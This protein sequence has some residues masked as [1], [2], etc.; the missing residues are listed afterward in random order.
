MKSIWRH[1]VRNKVH[2]SINLFGL[3]L[4]LT[5]A[6]FIYLYVADELSYDKHIPG[7]E[8]VIRLQPTV[9][10]EEGEQTWATSEGFILPAMAP[11]YPEIE[12][13][14]RVIRLENDMVI[15]VGQ[16]QYTQSGV[17]TADSAF[18]DVFPM[19]Y[20]Y[21]T[22][23]SAMANTGIIITRSVSRKL[24]GDSD[25]TG[26]SV[27]MGDN[28]VVIAAVVEDMPATSHFRF[29]MIIPLKTYWAES[30]Q[31]RNMYAF[32]SYI[33][34]R[35]GVDPKIFEENV[36]NNWYER[37]GYAD[38]KPMSE[39]SRRIVLNA[40]PLSDIHLQSHEE[41]EFEANGSSH[42]IYVFIGA[43]VL[44]MVIAMINF[45]N[46]SNAIAIRRAKEVA[47]R[48]TIGASKQLL[49]FRFMTESF[50]F[51]GISV[52]I[53]VAITLSL[54]PDFNIFVGKSLGP[55]IFFQSSFIVGAFATW[56]VIA[57][58]SGIYP[59]SILSSYDAVSA[60]KA[61]PSGMYQGSWSGY[62]RRALIVTQF[63]ISAIMIVVSSIIGNQLYF[64]ENRDTG[65]DKNNVIVLPLAGAT[66]QK[67]S[68][69]KTE[70]E[71]V[72]GVLSVAAS[73]VIPGKRVV[74]LIV[75]VPDLAG[76]REIPGGTDIGSR[77]MR[78]ISVDHDFVKTLGLTMA[79]G[80]D[81][82]HQQP[83]DS[84]EAFILNEAAVKELNLS[85]PVGR[86]FEY[87]FREGKR[88]R[89]IGVVKDFNFASVHSKIEPVML[90]IFPPMYSY[91][92]IKVY[93]ENSERVLSDIQSAWKK[94][95]DAPFS[96]EFLD[97]TYDSLYKTE[98]T[99]RAVVSWFMAISMIIAGLGLFGIIT[100]FA[101]MRLKE[102]GIRKV[103]GA[104]LVSLM[105]GLSREYLVLV[106]IG[107]AVAAY[108]AFVLSR[109]WLEQF[110]F[111][112]DVSA[113]T[114]LA[115]FAISELVAVLSIAWVVL[116]T[117]RMN[118]VSVLKHE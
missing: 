1:F 10:G 16:D 112:I 70:L 89:I 91:M 19:T 82:S 92:C 11:M 13:A 55:G 100:M 71:R 117:A 38:N 50:V 24:F 110:A 23:A 72:N 57:S 8:Q 116:R 35:D 74:I 40:M 63:T 87:T 114:F 51:V 33:R 53:S 59:A 113:T 101:Q 44:L 109:Q 42:V 115:G 29:T 105:N 20:V 27:R 2:M 3:T 66:R 45:I 60:L 62:L 7:Y 67:A 41:K 97:S 103:M 25:P 102:V 78:V 93:G 26:K 81:F 69:L 107:N 90:H 75:R 64:I 86:N 48:K 17:L 85:S 108:P 88:G 84:A 9:S 4:G 43:G 39:R 111:R 65:F 12:A 95:T 49:F 5:V 94:I 15:H 54:L 56:I 52:V 6:I 73:S 47:I 36:L 18:F 80:R 96:W 28:E 61:G 14:A 37:F 22:K 106:V 76:T 31:S 118:P 34:L 30:D 68:T 98:Q 104:S 32:Y 99:T 58:I 83:S 79:D 21:G 46:L 77:E